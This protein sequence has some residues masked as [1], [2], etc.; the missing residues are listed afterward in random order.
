MKWKKGLAIWVAMLLL[1]L[2][3]ACGKPQ[4][5]PEPSLTDAA[6]AAAEITSEADTQQTD[7]SQNTADANEAETAPPAEDVFLRIPVEFSL[8]SGAGAWNASLN[9]YGDGTFSGTFFNSDYTAVYS[10]SYSGRFAEVRQV[11]TY[12]YSMKVEDLQLDKEPDVTEEKDGIKFVSCEPYGI[13]EGDTVLLY[14]HGKPGSELPE[15]FVSLTRD[16]L[17][18]DAA[19]PI[20]FYGLYNTDQGVPFWSLNRPESE[21]EK[22]LIRIWKAE[23]GIRW[24]EK[25][26][27]SGGEIRY[28]MLDDRS[29]EGYRLWFENAFVD[30]GILADYYLDPK[31]ANGDPNGI[32]S[33]TATQP[34]F[35]GSVDGLVPHTPERK[36]TVSFDFSERENGSIRV[37]YEDNAW[38]TFAFR[39]NR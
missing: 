37:R 22:E 31:T 4:K 6:N 30:S 18:Y 36:F 3:A 5:E 14:L 15:N 23:D 24:L 8:Y 35:D 20:D 34:A 7:P 10:C 29:E 33:F 2:S 21:I 39:M 38:K 32:I 25:P 13:G 9:I 19:Y 1:A 27:E 12:T 17:H 26:Y 28:I 16:M 11:D